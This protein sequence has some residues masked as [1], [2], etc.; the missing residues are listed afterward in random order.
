[1]TTTP[2]T[3]TPARSYERA[4]IAFAQNLP[5][6][7]G[8]G[9]DADPLLHVDGDGRVLV[10]VFDGLGGSGS[11]RCDGP[12]GVQSSAYYGARVAR[13]I[14]DTFLRL[15]ACFPAATAPAIARVLGLQIDAALRAHYDLWGSAAGSALRSSLFRR[16]P[17]TAAIAVARPSGDAAATTILWAGDSR[18]YALS[19][20]LGLQQL[21]ADHLRHS[22]DALTNLTSDAPIARCISADAPTE[23]DAREAAL[24]LPVILLAAT[25][26]CFAYL[27]TPMHFEALLLE[28]LVSASSLPEWRNALCARISAVAGDDAS[29]A[30]TA[31][32][33]STYRSLRKAF[34]PRL[35]VL[36]TTYLDPLRAA[37]DADS[38][39]RTLW[40]RYAKT[41]EAHLRD[42]EA[43]PCTT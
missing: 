18:C 16:L 4:G 10:G 6:I 29:F 22:E 38:A 23:L 24:P 19:P 3:P 11:T 32:G 42:Q 43:P 30:L 1:M 17:T 26:G 15:I 33:W 8:R 40:A 13:A 41:Y 35:G 7:A 34:K 20:N 36:T 28:T 25:D 9:E 14:T 39:R 2:T 5:K 27:P 31:L 12:E 21:T 37:D